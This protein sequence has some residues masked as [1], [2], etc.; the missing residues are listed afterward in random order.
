MGQPRLEWRFQRGAMVLCQAR[1]QGACGGHAD[2]LADDRAHRDL[3]TVPATGQAQAGILLQQRSQARILTQ[4]L[5]DG[6]WVRIQVEHAPQ[7]ID[8]TQQLRRINAVQLQFQRV[9]FRVA[10]PA[11]DAQP[12]RTIAVADHARVAFRIHVFHAGQSAAAQEVQHRGEV[13]GRA[14]TQPQGHHFTGGQGGALAQ[15]ARRHAVFLAERGVET[16]QAAEACGQGDLGNRQRG[17]GQQ[18]LGEQQAARAMHFH[19]RHPKA[20]GEQAPQLAFA[21]SHFAGQGGEG[22]FTQHA[23]VDQLQGA[24]HGFIAAS[25]TAI[26]GRQ[27]RAA[28]QARAEARRFCARGMTVIDDIARLRCRRRT[29]RSAIDARAGDRGEEQPVEARITAEACLF[30]HVQVGRGMEVGGNHA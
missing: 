13:V 1:G 6:L 8:D 19:R 5:G 2:L 26:T 21:Q 20:I 10:L 23:L 14:I 12:T 7:A 22:C 29:D 9:C 24:R 4:C 16:G 28:T 25:P 27:F 18:L 11:A 15:V 30:A 3:E 17:F